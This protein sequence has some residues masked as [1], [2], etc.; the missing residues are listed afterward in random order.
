MAMKCRP[1][2]LLVFVG[3]ALVCG[4]GPAQAG[5]G[6]SSRFAR[7]SVAGGEALVHGQRYRGDFPDPSVLRVG[8]GYRAY[9]TNTAG[10]NLPI[11]RSNDLRTWIATGPG[12][13]VAPT[14]GFPSPPS[15][16]LTQPNNGATLWAPSVHRYDGQYVMFYSARTVSDPDRLCIGKAVAS[17]ARGPFVDTSSKPYWCPGRVGVIDPFFFAHRGRNYLLFKTDDN[18]FGRPARLWVKKLR[19]SLRPGYAPTRRL[20]TARSNWEGS[21]IENPAMITRRQKFYLF[22]S[23]NRWSTRHYATGYAMCDGPM[24][25]CARVP[26]RRT[27]ESKPTYP[28]LLRT[29]AVHSGPGGASPFWT[30]RGSLMLVHHAWTTGQEGYAATRD[31]VRTSR[32]CGQRRMYVARLGFRPQARLRVIDNDIAR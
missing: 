30:R 32:G 22:Y 11:L 24:G 13:E 15:W 28:P 18:R 16:A 21:L 12:G 19:P 5:E 7:A 1:V 10:V 4:L 20:L 6:D 26:Y 29:D 31:C 27:P 8:A 23:A 2:G 17:Q 14:E 9:G 3:L 25:P